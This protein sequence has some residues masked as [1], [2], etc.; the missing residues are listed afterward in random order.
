[1]TNM[2]PYLLRMIVASFTFIAGI[3]AA[4]FWVTHN[5]PAI[6]NS[7]VITS[8]RTN[9]SNQSLSVISCP[10]CLSITSSRSYHRI[11]ATLQDFVERK[12]D[13]EINTLY[14]SPIEHERDGTYSF[15]YWKE[16]KAV[17]LLNLD[18]GKIVLEQLSPNE[19]SSS[20]W[21]VNDDAMLDNTIKDCLLNGQ[22]ITFHRIRR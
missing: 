19:N 22:R 12:G 1:M 20:R 21:S 13:Y 2:K 4:R 9:N 15:I 17:L 8:S 11:L 14:V 7:I 6:Q 10:Q 18:G 3:T 5:A 16:A